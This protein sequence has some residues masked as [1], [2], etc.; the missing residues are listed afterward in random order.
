[1]AMSPSELLTHI[2][3]L[4]YDADETLMADSEVYTLMSLAE[5]EIAKETGCTE[6]TTTDTSVIDQREYDFPTDALRIISV[7]YDSVKLK[8]I[9]YDQIEFIE[10][11][12]YGGS[13]QSGDAV[14]YYEFAKKIGL[15]PIPDSAKTI[16]YL[17]I[18][19]PTT[20]SSTSTEFTIPDV[21]IQTITH[22]CLHKM[23]MKDQQKGEA[24]REY[25]LWLQGLENIKKDWGSTKEI[26]KLEMV[27]LEELYGDTELGI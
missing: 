16:K 8:K 11:I 14:Y 9:I 6:A 22:F 19:I 13:S 17:Y 24:D 20:L 3:S 1:M 26:D 10:G 5:L 12:S 4:S 21:Y 7:Y 23:F 25:Q 27:R 15:S 2:R 18:K